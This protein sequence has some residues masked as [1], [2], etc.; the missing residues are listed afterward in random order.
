MVRA[1]AWVTFLKRKYCPTVYHITCLLKRIEDIHM[2]KKCS[3]SVYA[4]GLSADMD[5]QQLNKIQDGVRLILEGLGEDT[6]RSGLL[7]TPARVARA[8]HE[9]MQP[10]R[11]SNQTIF[12]KSFNA[13]CNDIVVVK[14]IAFSSL[15]EHH[16]LPFYGVAHI[17][18]LPSADGHVCGLSKLARIVDKYAHRLQIQ[19]GLTQQIAEAIM[20]GTH[21]QGVYV[22]M[23]ATHT[24]MSL[25]GV[26]KR[27]ST[28]RTQSTLGVFTNMDK[29]QEVMRLLFG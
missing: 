15:C 26:C 10:T 29:K 19:E 21:A 6:A 18:Y 9:F 16:L 20:D 28:T 11:L 3:D 22:C 7:D 24:C 13:Q 1:L 23:D 4:L 2:N 17:A 27:E 8:L 12:E 25:R 5:E 14:N